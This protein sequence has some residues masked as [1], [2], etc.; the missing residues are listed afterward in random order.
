MILA[1]KKGHTPHNKGKKGFK[2][3]EKTRRKMSES[4]K[5]KGLGK[6]NP[7][8]GK[9]QSPEFKK[10]MSERMKGENHPN[11]GKHPFSEK[12]LR[13]MSES[14]KGFKPSEETKRKHSERMKGEKNPMYGKLRT[15]EEKKKMSENRKGIPSWNKDKTGVYSEESL[16]RMSESKK[17][18]V[19][20]KDNPMFGKK[21]SL[22][23]RKII[24]EKRWKQVIPVKDTKFELSI[25]ALLREKGIEFE[26]H[27]PIL[28]QP[29]IFIE[30]NWC[31]FLD[32]DYHHANPSKYPD[33]AIIWKERISKSTGRHVPA[34]T[35][36]MVREKDERIRQEL[37]TDGYKIIPAW[38]SD[39]KKDPEK[40]LQKIIKAIKKSKQ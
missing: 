36:K 28:G 31:I 35:A 24:K 21:Q 38:Y 40:C 20:G 1:F 16:R 32:S 34:T 37:I 4:K 2:Q 39:W 23:A 19:S 26:K 15:E 13:K 18:K 12:T 3:T 25:Q 7:M 9:K 30:P 11:Y 27:K 33:D 5:G 29:D 8:F 22:E 14:H 6:D 17:G 10:K